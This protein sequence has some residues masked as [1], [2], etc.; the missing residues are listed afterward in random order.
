MRNFNCEIIK[1]SRYCGKHAT[2]WVALVNGQPH[3]VK[4]KAEAQGF[5][6]HFQ[7]LSRTGGTNESTDIYKE[8]ERAVQNKER[9]HI[10][11][12]LHQ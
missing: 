6:N 12:H 7:N 11:G 4:S 8:D 10:P 3:H 2:G 1:A 9:A 5:M